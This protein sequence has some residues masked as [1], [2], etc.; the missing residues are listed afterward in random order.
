[1]VFKSKKIA[2]TSLLQK[3]KTLSNIFLAFPDIEQ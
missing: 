2:I 1:M 3:R